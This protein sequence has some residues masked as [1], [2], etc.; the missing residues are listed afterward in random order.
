MRKKMKKVLIT[1]VAG[2]MGSHLADSFLERG[3]YVTGIDNLIGGY[4]ENIPYGVDFHQVDL[5]N[6]EVIMDLFK[7][8]DLVVH[9]AC[10]AYEGL[11]VFSPALVVRNTMQITA[12]V[13]SAC[14][15]AK[16]PKIVYL[17]SMARY[18]TQEVVPFIES[19]VPNP[20][21]PYGIAKLSSELLIKNIAETHGMKFTILVPHNIIGPRQKFDDP[22]RNV[23]SIMINRILQD[24]PPIIYGDGTQM[25]CFSFMTDVVTPIMLACE[26]DIA[27]GLTINIGPDEEYLSINELAS[28]IL[29]LTDSNLTPIYMPGR[30]QE[31]KNANCSADLARRI[32]NYQTT[33]TLE[34]GLEKLIQ[35]IKEHGPREFDYHLPIE[36]I[37]QETPKT[38][39][40]RLI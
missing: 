5:D 27:N 4:P 17:S 40:D 10:T 13:M 26:S 14:V 31:V 33:T 38:W 8:V 21:D 22:F 37:T 28:L 11:S 30:P 20:Q 16:V 24:K 7:N 6:L 3:W 25:R 29:K 36:F 2:F 19:L 32:L 18:G 23:A 35:Y 1:G 34:V 9:A 39:T 12:N 15:R